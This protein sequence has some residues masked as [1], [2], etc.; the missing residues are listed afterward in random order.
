MNKKKLAIIGFH[1]GSAGQIYSY[2]NL[3]ENF[4]EV[5]FCVGE[6]DFNYPDINK[7]LKKR[8]NKKIEF[9]FNRKFYNVDF[10]DY[11]NWIN[12]LIENNFK[13]AFCINPDNQLREKEIQIC[14]EHSIELINII[15]PSAIIMNDVEFGKNIWINAGA[16]IGYKSI[17]KDGV[18]INSSVNLDHHNVVGYMSQIDPGVTTAGYVSIGD[19][20]HIHT[21]SIII[22][23]VTIGHN[24]EVGA[25]SLVLKNIE[26][27]SLYYGNPAK[28]IRDK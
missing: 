12:Y 21:A 6:G 15:H 18:I 28:K 24:S 22:N 14:K 10:I 23:K 2:L 20:C 16:F 26:K 3:V 1:D 7:E 9:P 11:S 8:H 19:F 17:I 13:F 5:A 27:N 4:D 25:G